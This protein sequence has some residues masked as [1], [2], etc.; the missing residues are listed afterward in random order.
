M[1]VAQNPN[2]STPSESFESQSDINK[3]SSTISSELIKGQP[4]A[5]KTDTAA[6]SKHLN[7][8][9]NTNKPKLITL[10]EYFKSQPEA[11]RIKHTRNFQAAQYTTPTSVQHSSILENSLTGPSKNSLDKISSGFK[12]P[13]TSL[14]L[15]LL[16]DIE[17]K[18]TYQIVA[19]VGIINI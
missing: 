12:L 16:A 11:K 15:K 1:K 10:Y 2:S 5:N 9:S 18:G 8:Q 19:H 17:T 6:A 7:G 14:P 3:P 13:C 4:D